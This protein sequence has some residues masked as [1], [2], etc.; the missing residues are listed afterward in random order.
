MIAQLNDDNEKLKA[1]CEQMPATTAVHYLN[2][3]TSNGS[4]PK[5]AADAEKEYLQDRYL[6]FIEKL[7]AEIDAARNL[8]AIPINNL[9]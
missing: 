7:Y 8:L 5:M 4:L 3:G 1:I 9:L 6:P 2:M